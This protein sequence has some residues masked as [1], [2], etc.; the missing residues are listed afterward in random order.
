MKYQGDILVIKSNTDRMK[1]QNTL[2]VREPVDANTISRRAYLLWEKAGRP[3]GRDTEF[4][5]QAETQLRTESAAPAPAAAQPAKQVL[6]TPATPTHAETPKPS[7]SLPTPARNPRPI[8]ST[9]N[10]VSPGPTQNPRTQSPAASNPL[11][12]SPKKRKGLGK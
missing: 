5:L 7:A 6:S 9:V 3:Q 11:L 10:E 1:T 2:D 8:N 12:I 4:W